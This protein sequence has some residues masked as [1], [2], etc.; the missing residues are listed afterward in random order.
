MT[1]ENHYLNNFMITMSFIQ[2]IY[3]LHFSEFANVT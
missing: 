2:S 1:I 3:L